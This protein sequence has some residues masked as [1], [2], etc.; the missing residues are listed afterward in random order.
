MLPLQHSADNPSETPLSHWEGTTN[1]TKTDIC[2]LRFRVKGQG[3]GYV[4][5]FEKNWVSKLLREGVVPELLDGER[6]SP[7]TCPSEC[8]F[9][10]FNETYNDDQ[11][12]FSYPC[13]PSLTNEHSRYR[14]KGSNGRGGWEAASCMKLPFG[15]MREPY[16]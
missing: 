9:S 13:R 2:S 16:S 1:L 14:G 15:C 3:L 12:T 11:I 6:D 8:L 10:I 5:R 4:F 7:N